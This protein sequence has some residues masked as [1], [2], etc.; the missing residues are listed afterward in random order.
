[1][2]SDNIDRI[3]PSLHRRSDNIDRIAPSLHMHSDNIDRTA[4][5]L[6][7]RSDN[8]DQIAPSLHMRSDTPPSR[9]NTA[10]FSFRNNANVPHSKTQ[11]NVPVRSIQ[12][13]PLDIRSSRPGVESRWVVEF[14]TT[15]DV[16]KATQSGLLVDTY[17]LVF[18]QH[19]DVTSCETAAYRNYI[20]VVNAQ[21]VIA[22][23]ADNAVRGKLKLC[24][25]VVMLIKV[26]W[27]MYTSMYQQ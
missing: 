13:D 19:D 18:Y 12:F 8:I 21:A 16:S 14:R 10:V 27:D 17:R 5:S 11:L 3:A 2:R 25:Y 22:A 24:D 1:M 9:P 23:S 7:M 20:E 15:A 26:P 6:H 4:P